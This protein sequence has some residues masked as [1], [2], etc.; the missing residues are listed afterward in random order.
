M[1]TDGYYEP[2]KP[3]EW[4]YSEDGHPYTLDREGEVVWLDDETFEPLS[5]E[6]QDEYKEF[7]EE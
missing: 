1:I 2:E 5:P 3:F 4:W 6:E 7:G